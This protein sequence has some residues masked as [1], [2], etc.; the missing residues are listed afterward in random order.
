MR[1]VGDIEWFYSVSLTRSFSAGD[2]GVIGRSFSTA[3]DVWLS[4]ANEFQLNDCERVREARNHG[5]HTLVF[6]STANGVVEL[7]SLDM[8]SIDHGLLYMAKSVF[9]NHQIPLSN[10]NVPTDKDKQQQRVEIDPE[11]LAIAKVLRGD[12]SSSD[13]LPSDSDVPFADAKTSILPTMTRRR[14]RRLETTR[15]Q[16]NHVEAERQR[17]ERLNQRF[18]ALRSAVPNVSKMDKASLLSDAVDYISKLK[19]RITEL[20]AALESQNITTRSKHE[21]YSEHNRTMHSS[22]SASTTMGVEVKILGTEAVVRVQSLNVNHPPA[23]LMDALRDL[24]LQILNASMS[25]IKEMVLQD[26]VV[27]VPH[28]PMSEE[29]M[30]D[31]I[32]QRL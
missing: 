14:Q 26:V 19:A 17:R 11:A 7:G 24:D 4:G 30:K 22:S 15:D 5:I 20:E 12:G 10:P 9:H 21:T 23:R 13:S 27:R 18:Y 25:N 29:A 31:A 6:I 3:T 8:L 32:L 28:D 16:P 1:D 2:G